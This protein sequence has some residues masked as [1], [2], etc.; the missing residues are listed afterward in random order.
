MIE[1]IGQ[2]GKLFDHDSQGTTAGLAL[3]VL[4]PCLGLAEFDDV[5]LSLVVVCVA[6]R[7]SN[8]NE[9]LRRFAPQNDRLWRT[10][11]IM[12]DRA[13]VLYLILRQH[14]RGRLSTPQ[15]LGDFVTCRRILVT[16]SHKI[17]QYHHESSQ[18]S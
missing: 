10:P 1:I 7:L 4:S 13:L 6:E 12:L 14:S 11:Q 5:M 8:K 15:A 18:K 9:I 3:I 2:M 16:K 17:S